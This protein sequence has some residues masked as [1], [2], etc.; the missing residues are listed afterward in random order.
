ME[1][2]CKATVRSEKTTSH[3]YTVL[4]V[5]LV[6]AMA[7]CSPTAQTYGRSMGLL[8]PSV[9]VSCMQQWCER[10][11][12]EL[13][14][15]HAAAANSAVVKEYSAAT[16]TP[17]HRYSPRQSRMQCDIQ[18]TL[19]VA[20]RAFTDSALCCSWKARQCKQ[21]PDVQCLLTSCPGQGVVN[22]E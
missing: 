14:I 19:A 18:F 1:P 2:L 12:G 17:F 5:Q 11:T 16:D 10:S 3:A 15:M 9:P 22:D 8:V 20:T 4:G 21:S 13:Y 7:A 6:T